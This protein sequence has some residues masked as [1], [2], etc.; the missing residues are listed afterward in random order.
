MLAGIAA[1]DAM[2]C[3]AGRTFRRP[4][5]QVVIDDLVADDMDNFALFLASPF[6][7]YHR[8][9]HDGT[10]LRFGGIDL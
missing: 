9:R 4:V 7:A 2:R 1:S 8:C 10:A 6:H 3:D 5:Q